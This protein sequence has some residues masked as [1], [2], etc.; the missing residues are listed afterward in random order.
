MMGVS[1]QVNSRIVI[2]ASE[3]VIRFARSGGPGG[4]HVNKVATRVELS[5]D[6]AH[7]PSLTEEDRV[8][9]L[10]AL[11]TRLTRDGSL[12][13]TVDSSRS[14]W[15]NREEAIERLTALLRAALAP[16]KK[17]TPTSPTRASRTRRVAGKRLRSARK[18]LRRRP[19]ADGN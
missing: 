7:S 3:L 9:L 1:L 19:E 5:F 13:I 12:T 14:Q 18:A 6:V 8:I 10:A 17:R 2:P 15:R 11:R 4:Q 16:R